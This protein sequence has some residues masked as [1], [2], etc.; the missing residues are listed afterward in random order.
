MRDNMISLASFIVSISNMITSTDNIP[1]DLK[2]SFAILLPTTIQRSYQPTE[3]F[4]LHLHKTW[5]D[6]W[7]D[8]KEIAGVRKRVNTFRKAK[9]P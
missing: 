8:W 9:K 4:Y 5:D 1:W 6:S 3:Q 2:Y 7:I